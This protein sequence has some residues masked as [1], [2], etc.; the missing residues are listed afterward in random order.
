MHLNT[1]LVNE[2][3][4]LL[5]G[6]H[7]VHGVVRVALLHAYEKLRR[8]V[9]GETRLVA[10]RRVAAWPPMLCSSG[11]S[12]E[13]L[14]K[15]RGGRRVAVCHNIDVALVRTRELAAGRA[16]ACWPVQVRC[17]SVQRLHGLR[18]L[19]D[20]GRHA[21]LW[22]VLAH[23]LLVDRDVSEHGAN[24]LAEASASDVLCGIYHQCLLRLDLGARHFV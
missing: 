1:Q 15:L 23:A 24:L 8:Q 16:N 14:P 20:A 19:G 12:V 13:A 18:A 11:V 6:H 10:D 17:E 21:W 3:Q 4:V 22:P 9:Q 5:K 7:A 2:F